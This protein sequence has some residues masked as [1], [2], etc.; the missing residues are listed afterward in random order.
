MSIGFQSVEARALAP[1]G[2]LTGLGFTWAPFFAEITQSVLAGKFF[3]AAIYRGLGEMV[4]I[5]PYGPSVPPAVQKLVN[6]SAEEI[7]KGPDGKVPS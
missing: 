7:R 3:G 2:W 5:A 4:A 6:A 1:K